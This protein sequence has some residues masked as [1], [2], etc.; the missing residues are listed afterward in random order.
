MRNIRPVLPQYLL[1]MF[2]FEDLDL[3]ELQE[4]EFNLVACVKVTRHG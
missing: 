1:F 2:F 4:N 3:L